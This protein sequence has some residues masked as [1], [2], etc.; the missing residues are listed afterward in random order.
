MTITVDQIRAAAEQLAPPF[1]DVFRLH[2][3]ERRS[4][5][6]IATQLAIPPLTVGTRLTRA[7]QKLRAILV[8]RHG[9]SA[10]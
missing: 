8:Q 7:R 1:R 9:A 10:P 6:E 5:A 2:V 3:F 4:Y